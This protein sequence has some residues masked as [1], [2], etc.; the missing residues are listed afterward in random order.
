[1][2]KL[3]ATAFRQ[4]K[5][6]CYHGH[7]GVVYFAG[8]VLNHDLSFALLFSTTQM[9][10]LYQ[11][12]ILKIL[13]QRREWEQ[14]LAMA[15]EPVPPIAEPASPPQPSSSSTAPDAAS[16]PRAEAAHA[17]AGADGGARGGASGGQEE[18]KA[19]NAED[20]DNN[21]GGD[22]NDSDDGSSPPPPPA[23]GGTVAVGAAAPLSSPA[24][25][26]A[27]GATGA[28][29]DA[30]GTGRATGSEPSGAPAAAA[31]VAT[32]Q[33]KFFSGFIVVGGVLRAIV[34]GPLGRRCI[35]PLSYSKV[36]LYS[37]EYSGQSGVCCWCLFIVSVISLT[38]FRP[39]C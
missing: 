25:G 6:L 13:Q 30:G 11:P 1:M 9:N 28:G 8:S 24:V 23:A 37:H 32:T 35:Y 14:A 29:G 39:G 27:R 19:E 10:N 38:S 33:A 21:D 12:C 2:E 4:E 36:G 16:R 26:E 17:P 18:E 3:S 34:V 20:D 5:I 7:S 22:G 15:G 31:A